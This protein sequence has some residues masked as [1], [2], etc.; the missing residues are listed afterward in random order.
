VI[1]VL[2]GAGAFLF[3]YL[4]SSSAEPVRESTSSTEKTGSTQQPA[5]IAAGPDLS[6]PAAAGSSEYESDLEKADFQTLMEPLL[7]EGK[8]VES[9]LFVDLNGDGLKE[10]LVLVRGPGERRP[11]DWY[12]YALR[13]GQPAKLFERL[14][15]TVGELQVQGP[16]LVESEGVYLEG[17]ADCCP[18]WI[19][20]T[21]Y[22]WKDGSLVV[23]KVEAA[24]AGA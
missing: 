7:D 8:S 15:V 17:D 24:P 20:H 9:V 5:I 6:S 14:R 4:L 3:L 21:Y 16:R 12:Y 23:L 10:A 2:I 18:S 13:G 1:V 22:V 11:L 19:K